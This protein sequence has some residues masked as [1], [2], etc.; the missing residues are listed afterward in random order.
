MRW[1]WSGCFVVG[2]A[3]CGTTP[4]Q[5]SPSLTPAAHAGE[6]LPRTTHALR[7]SPDVFRVVVD[8]E[9]VHVGGAL[10]VAAADAE[11]QTFSIPAL[12]AVIPPGCG[13][14]IVSGTA[15]ST[16]GLFGRAAFTL[17]NAGVHHVLIEAVGARGAGLEVGVFEVDVPHPGPDRTVTGIDMEAYVGPHGVRLHS[18][19]LGYTPTLTVDGVGAALLRYKPAGGAG[20]AA[21]MVNVAA[22]VQTF[23]SVR[24]AL[25]PSFATIYDGF[26]GGKYA[27]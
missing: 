22:D 9:G 23:I 12:A 10:I 1:G 18:D 13:E 24:D 25:A 26:A 17:Q 16:W 3:S 19:D 11:S 21:V 6:E 5:G 14:A 4:D 2:L 8:S 7:L 20:I 27:P 15:H